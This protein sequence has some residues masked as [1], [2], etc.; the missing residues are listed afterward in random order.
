MTATLLLRATALPLSCCARS[1]GAQSLALRG[2]APAR[3]AAAA[4]LLLSPSLSSLPL[5]RS[6][7]PRPRAASRG[8]VVVLAAAQGGSSKAESDEAAWRQHV[9]ELTAYMGANGGSTDVPRHEVGHPL[10]PLSR[11]V[12]KTRENY[13]KGALRAERV[14]ELNAL[15]FVWNA[16]DAKWRKMYNQVLDYRAL[17]GTPNVPVAYGAV[18]QWLADQKKSW[19]KNTL[20]AE[21]VAALQ[22]AGVSI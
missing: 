15:G 11:W 17:H 13:K 6:V 8:A 18:G 20:S 10:Y 19:R 9:A 12:N 4:S 7:A 1:R 3:H 14:T 22:A 5:P 21:R 16:H 2:A